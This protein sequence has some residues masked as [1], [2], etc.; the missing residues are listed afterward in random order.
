MLSR[1]SV[2]STVALLALIAGAD[3]VGAGVDFDRDVRPVLAAKCFACHGPDAEARK[4][5]LQM[6]EAFDKNGVPVPINKPPPPDARTGR[7]ASL[8]MVFCTLKDEEGYWLDT[9]ILELL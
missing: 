1:P 2:R 6:S 5:E 4:E 7:W 8:Q 3:A 9:G